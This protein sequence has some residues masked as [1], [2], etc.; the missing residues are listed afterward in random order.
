MNKKIFLILP[1]L[2]TVTSCKKENSLKNYSLLTPKGAPSL[3][4]TQFINDEHYQ[5]NVSQASSIP[6]LIGKQEYDVV[7]FDLFNAVKLIQNQSLDYKLVMPLTIGNAYLVGLDNSTQ[8]NQITDDDVI[9]SFGSNS[10]FTKAFEK[11]HNVSVDN[12]VSDVSEALKVAKT[13]QI[14]GVQADYV[15]LAEPVLT[16][17]FSTKTDDSKFYLKENIVT[18]WQE[19]TIANNLNN[20]KGFLGFPQA[21]LFIKSSIED[22]SQTETVIN[23]IKETA[24]DIASNNGEQTLSKLESYVDSGIIEDTYFGQSL[25]V[26]KK[27]INSS[28][29]PNGITN[30]LAFNYESY[31]VNAFIKE[32]G[33]QGLSEIPSSLLSKYYLN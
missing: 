8:D 23:T 21:G 9:V 6:A 26:F 31:D 10:I 12:Q 13:G 16:A 15:I 14:E 24:N 2:L 27:T 22:D 1:L 3:A 17:L 32:S 7:I 19:Y 20:G 11:M 33:L 28:L 18:K 29:N 25:S 30:A 4:Y 5:V